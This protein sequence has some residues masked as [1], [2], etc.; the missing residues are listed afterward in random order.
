MLKVV[1]ARVFC[2]FF[3]QNIG[4]DISSDLHILL[5]YKQIVASTLKLAIALNIGF[6]SHELPRSDRHFVNYK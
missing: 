5:T 2:H 6:A 4:H 3:K 1:S